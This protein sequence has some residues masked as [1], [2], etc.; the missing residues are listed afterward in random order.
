M[1]KELQLVRDFHRAFG[2]YL[3]E[4]PSKDI[5]V[6]SKNWRIKLMQEELVEVIQAIE[7]ESIE[8]L[9]KEL[10][11]LMYVLLGTVETYGLG[12]KFE[13]IFAEVHASNMSKLDKYGKPVLR[14]DGKIAKP[15]TYFKADIKKILESN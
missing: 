13:E 11:D 9:A 10:A 7:T 2:I 14:K 12:E 1:R 4:F 15:E 8:D 6:E 5:P 3:G